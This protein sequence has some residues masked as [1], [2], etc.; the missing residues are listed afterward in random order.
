VSFI[1]DYSKFTWIYLLHHKSKFSK[2]FFE[3]HKL[4]GR[5]VDRKIIVVQSN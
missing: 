2:Y 1:D 4:V 3:F 5:M